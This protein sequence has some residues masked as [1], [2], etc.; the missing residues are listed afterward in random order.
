MFKEKNYFCSVD[1]DVFLLV[2]TPPP[3]YFEGQITP[4]KGM[5][6]NPPAFCLL[7]PHVS[8]EENLTRFLSHSHIF[9]PDFEI[10][11]FYKNNGAIVSH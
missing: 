2:P 10:N 9:S 8:A 4:L 6:A 3:G 5:V 7:F 1:Y 11:R